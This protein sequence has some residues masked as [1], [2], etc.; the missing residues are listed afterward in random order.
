M[1]NVSLNIK[2]GK[3]MLWDDC[4]VYV[5]GIHLCISFVTGN[6]FKYMVFV[7]SFYHLDFNV[8]L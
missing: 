5:C 7:L 1:Y 8:L 4:L 2:T 6:V 3:F